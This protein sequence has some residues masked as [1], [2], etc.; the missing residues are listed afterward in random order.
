MTIKRRIT[1]T[2]G[3]L[4]G[5]ALVLIAA[6]IVPSVSRIRTLRAEILT[7][8]TKIQRRYDL[9]NYVRNSI[10]EIDRTRKELSDLRT[11]AVHEG[12]ELQFVEALEHAAET[13]GVEMNLDLVTANQKDIS[14]WERWIP[15]QISATGDFPLVMSFLNEVEHL[16]YYV[17]F[18]GITV[19]SGRMAT[20]GGPGNGTVTANFSGNVYWQAAAVPQVLTG[21]GLSL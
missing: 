5:A 7:E 2:I 1:I 11:I 15:L 6:V 14:S 10:N 18:D 8:R 12:E 20:G 9:R 21:D 3:V 13:T 19:S 4:G 16:P 17:I